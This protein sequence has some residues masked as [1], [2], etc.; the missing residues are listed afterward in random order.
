MADLEIFCT[1]AAEQSVTR[2]AARLQRVQSNVTTRVRGLEQA[3]GTTLFLRE[4]RRMALTPEGEILHGYAQRLLALAEEARQALRPGEPAGRLRLGS[5]ESTAA[6]RLPQPLA[7]FHQRWPAVALE[8]S[9]APSQQLLDRVR[10]HALDATLVAPYADPATGSDGL[11]ASLQGLPLFTEE[12]VLVL[13]AA[14]P[15]VRGPADVQALPLAAFETGCTYRRLALDWLAPGPP[16]RVLELGSY[17]AILAC[18]AAGAAIGVAPHSVLAL[19]R[20]P[21][22]LRTHLLR[23]VTTLLVRRR[24][25]RSAA[26]DALQAVLA[27]DLSVKSA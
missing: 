10:D 3:L 2:A 22:Q 5:M 20:E 7:Q 4:G 25:Y 26:L 11:D 12:L 8:L 9:T 16:R 23:R 27:P 17:H 14:H 1:V 6:S 21:L 19:Q 15:E 13:P 18:V 24:G